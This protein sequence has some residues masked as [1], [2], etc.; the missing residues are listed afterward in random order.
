MMLPA[1]LLV[2]LLFVAPSGT[3]HGATVLPPEPTFPRL[4]KLENLPVDLAEQLTGMT[5]S[6]RL[7]RGLAKITLQRKASESSEDAVLRCS[8]AHVHHGTTQDPTAYTHVE[9]AMAAYYLQEK[10]VH[11]ADTADVTT[12]RWE[13]GGSSSSLSAEPTS[14]EPDYDLSTCFDRVTTTL[15]KAAAHVS[16]Q[17][18]A[19]AERALSAL[20][21][22]PASNLPLMV[23]SGAVGMGLAVSLTVLCLKTKRRQ[24]WASDTPPVDLLCP[25]SQDLMTDPVLI[26]ETGQTY[27]KGTIT[28]WL[29]THSTD[30]ITNIELRSKRLVPNIAVRKIL[31]V[32]KDEHP[33]FEEQD[34]AA[35]RLA[36]F[37][38][39]KHSSGFGAAA[40]AGERASGGA[41]SMPRSQSADRLLGMLSTGLQRAGAAAGRGGRG[42]AGGGLPKRAASH[43]N[44]VGLGTS[45]CPPALH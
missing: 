11:A 2:T 9:D 41:S 14:T 19:Y 40:L 29:H 17:R 31:Q 28:S 37:Q 6:E 10:Y 36:Q 26:A 45:Q 21:R 44:L 25:I 20:S 12:A 39:R 32:W 7:L 13:S 24:G 34:E 8:D 4:K 16:Q 23:L 33:G 38:S 43:N 27:D 35:Q 1:V 15:T 22:D 3:S 18:A 30:P 5:S 42:A